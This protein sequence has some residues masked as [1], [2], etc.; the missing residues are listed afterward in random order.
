MLARC[1]N[2]SCSASFLR[3]DEGTLFLL[4]T[5]TT[6]GSKAKKTEYFWLCEHCSAGMTLRLAKDGSIV[7]AGPREALHDDSHSIIGE[8]GQFLRG[9]SFHRSGRSRVA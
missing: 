5:E 6:L 3:L 9:V 1:T 7:A 8:N 4:E 2:P